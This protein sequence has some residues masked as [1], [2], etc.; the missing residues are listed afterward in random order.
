MSLNFTLHKTCSKSRARLGTLITKHSTINTPVF[1]PVGT[2]ATVKGIHFSELKDLGAEI[3]L[4]NTYHLMLTPGQD[5]IKSQ[6]GLHSFMNWDKSILTDSGG[7]QVMSLSS[8][9]KIS[10]EGVKFR[11][12]L[13]GEYY[14][15]TPAKSIEIQHTLDSNI[16]MVFDECVKYPATYEETKKALTRTHNWAQKS[17]QAFIQREGYGIF[18]INQGGTYQDLRIDSA[19]FLS[20]INFNGYAVGGLA[21]GEPQN[22]MFEVLNYT[23]DHLPKNKPRYL[24]GVGRPQDILGAVELG[25]DMFDCVMPTRAGRNAKA[26]TSIG[27]LNIRNAKY[28]DSKD[29]LDS[30]CTCKTCQNYSLSYLHHLFRAKEMLGAMLLTYHNLHYYLNLMQEIREAIKTDTFLEYKQKTLSNYQ[31]NPN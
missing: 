15:L 17:Y 28:K 14:F 4:G 27:E 12:H 3:I 29:K 2:K 19:K 26:F 7:Y 30:N 18:G 23:T 16:T 10:D 5:I 11:S 13:S 24:M 6:G 22:I 25:I 20:D 8:L 21:V 31:K 1:M 9:N